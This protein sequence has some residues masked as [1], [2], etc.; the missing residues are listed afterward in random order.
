MYRKFYPKGCSAPKFYGLPKIHK[1]DTPLPSIVACYSS[2]ATG[3][4]KFLTTIFKSLLTTQK[5][6]I[7]Y[8]IDLVE[9]L[10][11]HSITE[12]TI[13]SSFDAISMY[14]S[15]DVHKCE[16]ALQKKLEENS[17]WSNYK[18]LEID[19]I[20][21]LVRLCNKF[22]LYFMF[23]KKNS[24]RSRPTHGHCFV[25]FFGKFLHGFHRTVCFE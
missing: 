19:T 6:Y 25:S 15:C 5:S 9:K 18:T 17:T 14:T 23:R 7:K 8:S 4:G 12:K 21:T 22:S 16:Q 2:P 11:N 13:L 24:F 3:V 10:K 1:K 20:M